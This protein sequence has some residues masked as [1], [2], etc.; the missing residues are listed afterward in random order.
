MKV[1]EGRLDIKIKVTAGSGMTRVY[2][3]FLRSHLIVFLEEII[4]K[5]QNKPSTL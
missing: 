3:A 2:H 5:F 1:D 4:S